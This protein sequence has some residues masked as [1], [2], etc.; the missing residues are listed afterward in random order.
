MRNNAAF[1]VFVV[2][3]VL[4]AGCGEDS[5]AGPSGDGGA[6]GDGGTSGGAPEII[7]G[8]TI[9]LT[10]HSYVCNDGGTAEAFWDSYSFNGSLESGTGPMGGL[11]G[12][13][14]YGETI[15]G[16]PVVV[17]Y[18]SWDWG[19]VAQEQHQLFLTFTDNRSG[20]F[21]GTMFGTGEAT[22]GGDYRGATFT[23][24]FRFR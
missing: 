13:W 9:D 10:Y 8:R 11:G 2:F 24:T 14:Q 22:C 16:Y 15:P 23:G 1:V 20:T 21:E 7:P 6:S 19:G 5:P 12:T 17:L 3:V 18:I 4:F